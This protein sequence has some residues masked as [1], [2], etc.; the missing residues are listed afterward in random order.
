VARL[1]NMNEGGQHNQGRRRPST[2]APG[3]AIIQGGLGLKLAHEASEDVCHRIWSP[4]QLRRGPSPRLD[5]LKNT[6]VSNLPILVSNCISIAAN[7]QG[8]IRQQL[9]RFESGSNSSE[10]LRGSWRGRAYP[11]ITLLPL[12]RS[13]DHLIN[14]IFTL[15]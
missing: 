15:T 4:Q 5:G 3:F 1:I 8:Q 9:H 12:S 13:S 11:G 6:T 7:Q 10:Q 2:A 14:H